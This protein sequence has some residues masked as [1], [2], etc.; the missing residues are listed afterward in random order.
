[1]WQLESEATK[2]SSGSTEDSSDWGSGT[3]CGELDAGTF[4]PPSNRHS[5]ARL[6]LLSTKGSSLRTHATV[7]V[8]VDI[9][10]SKV[11]VIDLRAVDPGGMHVRWFVP[12]QREAS[13]LN[14]HT[15]RSSS[16]RAAC[17]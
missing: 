10:P 7:T 6:Y 4:A 3:T 5:C 2:A 16:R 1:M 12:P 11:Q 17:R 8:C 9:R 15:A 14:H 13:R